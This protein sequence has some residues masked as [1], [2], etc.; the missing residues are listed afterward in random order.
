MT[1]VQIMTDGAGILGAKKFLQLQ[2][3][4]DILNG[5]DWLF[6]TSQNAIL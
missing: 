6:A 4:V 5:P 2:L 1:A 3:S